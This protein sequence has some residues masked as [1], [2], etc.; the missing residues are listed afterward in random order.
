MQK[1]VTGVRWTSLNTVCTTAIQLIQLAVVSRIL[2]PKEFGLMAMVMVISDVA[3]IFADIGLSSAII[4]RK[5]P[6]KNELSS[7]YWFNV[8]VGVIIFSVIYLITPVVAIMFGTNEIKSLLPVTA[9]SFL[10]SPF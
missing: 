3:G 1:T 7:L 4:Q 9:L 2:G 8:I 10:I 5:E 6:K